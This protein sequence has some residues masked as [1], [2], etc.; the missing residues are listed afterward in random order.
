MRL[1]RKGQATSAKAEQPAAL[2]VGRPAYPQTRQNT[3]KHHITGPD[4]AL[5]AGGRAMRTKAHHNT[6]RPLRPR[7]KGFLRGL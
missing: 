1:S 2:R 7:R 3:I 6:S 5:E 4:A